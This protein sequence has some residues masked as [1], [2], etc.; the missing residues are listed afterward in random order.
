M[1]DRI[2]AMT[3]P[4][5]LALIATRA[6]RR[7]RISTI[8]WLQDIYPEIALALSTNRLLIRLCRPWT[9]WRNTAWQQA[10]SCVA[11]SHDMA[12]VVG[13]N[14]VRSGQIC[15]IPNWAP[16]RDTLIPVALEQNVLRKQWGL[17][18]KFVAAYSGNLGRVH[19]FAPLLA[20]AALLRN[21]PD[22][23][24]LFI[25]TGPQRKNIEAQA[26]LQGLINVRF[27]PAQQQTRL[28]ESL[29]VA[30]IHFLTLRPGCERLVYPSKLY[31]IAAVAK[32]LVYVGPLQCELAR[33]IQQG[34]FGIAVSVDD[35]EALARAIR[36]L[37][38]DPVRRTTM[39][40]AAARWARETGGLAA[41]IHQWETLLGTTRSAS[42]VQLA[43]KK[44][45]APN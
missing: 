21:E 16:G 31:G 32:P 13:E 29:S 35:G 27:Q 37:R 19:V 12:A 43:V 17:E 20:A 1:G 5:A 44:P 26:Q 23:V 34:G 38:D 3:D 11:I 7:R 6:A 25:G 41:V 4:P 28:A 33:T 36:A 39:G 40:D 9:R 18:G 14:G 2:V 8:F 42:E 30:D 24:F 15:V 10:E 45:S 22:I